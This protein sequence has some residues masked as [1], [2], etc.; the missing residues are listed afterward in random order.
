MIKFITETEDRVIPLNLSMVDTNQFFI[1]IEGYLCQKLEHS[2][3]NGRVNINIIA[4]PDGTPFSN[5]LFYK[6]NAPI[7]KI[8]PRVI[9]I[10]FGDD[11]E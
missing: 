2:P 7:K 11:N 10:E 6:I 8:L 4:H 9:R 5:H 1:D 3:C